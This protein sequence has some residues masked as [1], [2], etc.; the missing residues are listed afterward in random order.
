M[1]ARVSMRQADIAQRG[2]K[3]LT[4]AER[5][6]DGKVRPVVRR[7][8]PDIVKRPSPPPGTPLGDGLYVGHGGTVT[9]M[10]VR[11]DQ[12]EAAMPTKTDKPKPGKPKAGK[13]KAAMP[14][15]APRKK[16]PGKSPLAQA[17]EKDDK[18]L[19][20]HL[21][22]HPTVGDAA[23]KARAGGKTRHKGEKRDA[24]IRRVLLGEGE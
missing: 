23:W 16:A 5:L 3:V 10:P 12:K 1:N 8:D 20:K 24:F 7:F 6:C 22:E 14:Q 15:S 2:R 4:P 13:P 18:A 9:Q 21:L 11:T 17:M 19:A